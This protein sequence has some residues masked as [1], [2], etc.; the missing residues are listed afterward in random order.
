[1][2]GEV[3]GQAMRESLNKLNN[4]SEVKLEIYFP[5]P[6]R[7]LKRL[8]KASISSLWYSSFMSMASR[9]SCMH[10]KAWAAVFT[11]S[12]GCDVELKNIATCRLHSSES[13]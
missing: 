12:L 9:N 11:I 3:K 1:M 7:L 4:P 6:S 5:K 13:S 10:L 8:R 2:Q